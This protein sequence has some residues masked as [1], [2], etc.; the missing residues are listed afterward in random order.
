MLG[1]IE[2]V[3]ILLFFGVI[4]FILLIDFDFGEIIAFGDSEKGILVLDGM[5]WAGIDGGCL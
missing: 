4:Y 1:A 2:N 5:I 3:P